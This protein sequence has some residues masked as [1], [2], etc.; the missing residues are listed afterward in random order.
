M[1]NDEQRDQ[2]PSDPITPDAGAFVACQR[3]GCT[4]A[5]VPEPDRP[6][7]DWCC[8]AHPH[9]YRVG[10]LVR[11]DRPPVPAVE[12]VA[13]AWQAR[14]DRDSIVIEPPAPGRP[15][16]VLYEVGFASDAFGEW[17]GEVDG[18]RLVARAH[19]QPVHGGTGRA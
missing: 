4:A 9:D 16:V 7:R 15:N 2:P 5:A 13:A 19:Y 6:I 3:T 18:L 10:D 14:R 11:Y 8:P 12:S 1:D 17:W